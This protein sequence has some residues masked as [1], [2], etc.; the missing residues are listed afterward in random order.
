MKASL[1]SI[2]LA[3]ASLYAQSTRGAIG[4][5]VADAAKKPVSGAAVA[6]VERDTNKKRT[7]VSGPQGEFL[8]TPAR[9]RNL[10]SRS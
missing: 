2:L 1:I 4:R 3:A 7:A 10:P 6:L 8:I 9:S 5:Q